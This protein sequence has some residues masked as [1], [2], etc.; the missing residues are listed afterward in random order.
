MNS[1][2]WHLGRAFLLGAAIGAVT[3]AAWSWL[4][5]GGF[6]V[7]YMSNHVLGGL[8]MCGVAFL[9]VAAFINWWRKN[10]L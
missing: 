6:E 9:A 4:D 2:R 3:G 1:R 8:F 5:Y 10:P 7:G